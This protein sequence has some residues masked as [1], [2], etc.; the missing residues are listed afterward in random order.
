MIY[1]DL[2]E[3]DYVVI[4]DYE[5]AWASPVNTETRGLNTLYA[6][7]FHEGWGYANDEQLQLLKDALSA[8]IAEDG[9]FDLF[10]RQTDNG[11]EYIHAFEY[12]NTFYSTV[13]DV[14]D[15]SQRIVRSV[16]AENAGLSPDDFNNSFDYSMAYS[17]MIQAETFYVRPHAASAS[18]PEPTSI[19]IFA[20]GLLLL[21]VRDKFL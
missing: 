11:I 7:E 6:P 1:S 19:L 10:T 20:L 12:W 3:D 18:I 21:S 16:W 4:G 17:M 15:I 5:W 8:D 9:Q 2:T 13:D 14:S